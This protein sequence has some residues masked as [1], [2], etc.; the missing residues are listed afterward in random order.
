M[1]QVEVLDMWVTKQEKLKDVK[2]NVMDPKEYAAIDKKNG[3]K[4]PS[5]FGDGRT[6][7]QRLAGVG[8]H[9]RVYEPMTKADQQKRYD[10]SSKDINNPGYDNS[11]Y[12]KQQR[13]K[14]S[15]AI[16]NKIIDDRNFSKETAAYSA[17]VKRNR[18]SGSTKRI[19]L[20]DKGNYPTLSRSDSKINADQDSKNA[21]G[22]AATEVA[23]YNASQEG[24]EEATAIANAT[25]NIK[26]GRL[27]L[28]EAVKA[29]IERI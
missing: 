26:S 25:A 27:K 18:E 5:E 11:E 20:S 24:Q 10:N 19:D 14:E 16:V 17:E 4:T 1:M 7:G 9:Q 13:Q 23:A 15:D 3:I 29:I 22:R 28:G 12:G 21:K 2:G 8:K 6:L